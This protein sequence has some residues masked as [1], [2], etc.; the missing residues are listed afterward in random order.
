[1][2]VKSERE[3]VAAEAATVP[4]EQARPLVD[5][6]LVESVACHLCDDA[7]SVLG[8]AE[9]AGKIRVRRVALDSEEGRAIARASRAP[10]PPIVLM[11]GELLGWGR[12]SRGK[13]QR[14]LSQIEAGA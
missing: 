4:V 14:R 9:R 7:A 2:P 5:A 13:L 10:M 3:A 8:E 1:M 6:V 12:L 11:D